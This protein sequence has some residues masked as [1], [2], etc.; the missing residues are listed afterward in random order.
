MALKNPV[1]WLRELTKWGDAELPRNSE[2]QEPAE[3]T[4][5]AERMDAALKRLQAQIPPIEDDD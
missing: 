5:P 2:P 4:T 1:K 3:P